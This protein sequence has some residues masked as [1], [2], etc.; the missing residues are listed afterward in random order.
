[1]S[2]IRKVLEAINSCGCNE[3]KKNPGVEALDFIDKTYQLSFRNTM[4]D[5]CKSVSD[6]KDF[7]R[8]SIKEID[9]YSGNL[10]LNQSQEDEFLT[11]LELILDNAE[12][13]LKSIKRK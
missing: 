9:E 11:K 7:I 8:T 3:A 2:R 1:M 4:K 5:E 10:K 13:V 6:V 12:N